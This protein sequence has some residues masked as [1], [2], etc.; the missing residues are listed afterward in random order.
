MLDDSSIDEVVVHWEATATNAERRPSGTLTIPIE[1]PPS[2]IEELL[3]DL[4]NDA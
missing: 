2:R 1:E 3:A 4:D